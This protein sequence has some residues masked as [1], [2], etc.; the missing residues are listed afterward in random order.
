[1][2]SG[3]AD[4]AVAVAPDGAGWA[5]A[6]GRYDWKGLEDAHPSLVSPLTPLVVASDGT[7]FAVD[8]VRRLVRVAASSP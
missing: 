1:V 6:I 3:A 4:M 2:V 8:A 5:S 7:V